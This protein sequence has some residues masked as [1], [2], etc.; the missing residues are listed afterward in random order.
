M[1][2][3][4]FP[5]CVVMALGFCL[6][7]SACEPSGESKELMTEAAAE[8]TIVVDSA[9]ESAAAITDIADRYYALTL[10]RTPEVAYFAGVNLPRH[11]GLEDNRPV[12][13][14]Q[15]E[16]EI[17]G[18]LAA[19]EKIDV[20]GL[21]GRSEWISHAYLL[22]T[23]KS[24]VALRICRTD[25]WNVNQ[26]GGWLNQKCPDGWVPCLM[27]RLKWFPSRSTKKARECRHTIAR[28]MMNGRENTGSRFMSRRNSPGVMPRVSPFT[29]PGPATICR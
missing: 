26:M 8:S 17:D 12:A 10:E 4:S 15:A 19:I 7:L 20:S 6:V 27:F 24:S 14:R 1:F 22:Q 5:S 11:D 29:R 16:A 28:A 13:R 25:L 23:L 9:D 18:M 21:G 2:L 3:N